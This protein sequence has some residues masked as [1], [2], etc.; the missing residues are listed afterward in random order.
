MP[1]KNFTPLAET[2][3]GKFPQDY[4]PVHKITHHSNSIIEQGFSKYYNMELLVDADVL[5]DSEHRHRF[6][7]RDDG[8]KEEVLVEINVMHTKRLDLADGKQRDA[9]ADGIP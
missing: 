9:N 8:G 2:R 6:H 1:S 4:Q 3:Q 7:S 5:K